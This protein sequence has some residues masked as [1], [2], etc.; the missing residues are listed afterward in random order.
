MW[1]DLYKTCGPFSV[2]VRHSV[3]SAESA[4]V[5]TAA[6]SEFFFVRRLCME[7]RRYDFIIGI[8]KQ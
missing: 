4:S 8:L 1:R 3:L 5:K 2:L 6:W 7:W